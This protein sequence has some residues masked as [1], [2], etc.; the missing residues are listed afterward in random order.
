MKLTVAILWFVPAAMADIPAT[1]AEQD[2]Q[3]TNRI[4]L[5]FILLNIA[6]LRYHH[7]SRV[8][9]YAILALNSCLPLSG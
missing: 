2:F 3:L 4:L 5:L 9:A 6:A 7:L 1:R 8:Q